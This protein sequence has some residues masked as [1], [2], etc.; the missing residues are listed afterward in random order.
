MAYGS[1]SYVGVTLKQNGGYGLFYGE[2]LMAVWVSM[3]CSLQRTNFHFH[4]EIDILVFD[5]T[6]SAVCVMSASNGS[7]ISRTTSKTNEVKGKCG[8]I[9]TARA[10]TKGIFPGILPGCPPMLIIRGTLIRKGQQFAWLIWR[11]QEPSSSG[12]DN[13]M[14][15]LGWKCILCNCTH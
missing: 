6:R 9:I 14:Q 7:R 4:A 12:I 1:T 3:R 2:E 15:V 11:L 10:R 13:T 8:V 5:F